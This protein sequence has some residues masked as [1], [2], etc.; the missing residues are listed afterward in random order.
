MCGLR[1]DAPGHSAQS[2]RARYDG[3]AKQHAATDTLADEQTG[4]A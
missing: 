2:R 1:D 4:E 3:L